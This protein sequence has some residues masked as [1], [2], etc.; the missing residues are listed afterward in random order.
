MRVLVQGLETEES[1]NAVLAKTRISSENKIQALYD[2]FC[3]GINMSAA[4]ALNGLT[5]DK[6]SEFVGEFHKTATKHANSN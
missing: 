2:Y 3:K 1:I 6:F 5:P 4:A